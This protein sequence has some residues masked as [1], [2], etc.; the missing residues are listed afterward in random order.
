[1]LRECLRA[2]SHLPH[3]QGQLQFLGFGRDRMPISLNS[4]LAI[5]LASSYEFRELLWTRVEEY[6]DV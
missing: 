2:R 1:M 4:A 5:G 6:M 3:G